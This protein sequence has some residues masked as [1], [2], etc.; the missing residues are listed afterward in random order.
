MKKRFILLLIC[1]CLITLGSTY[2]SASYCSHTG[3]SLISSYTTCEM[4]DDIKHINYDVEVRHPCN[5]CGQTYTNKRPLGGDGFEKHYSIRIVDAG[6]GTG[7]IHF[8]RAYCKC[9]YSSLTQ[10]ICNGPPCMVLES[11]PYETD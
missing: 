1:L 4:V 10:Y 8:Y 11:L 9:G 5:K 3:G 6:H 7:S 2:T